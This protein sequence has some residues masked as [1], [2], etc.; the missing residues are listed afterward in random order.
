MHAPI[1]RVT[2]NVVG[3]VP[4]RHDSER[5]PGKNY[6]PFG[7]RPLYH[8]VVA[9]LLASPRIS[10]VVLDTDSE[11]IRD[12]ARAAFPNVEVIERPPHLRDGLVP[13]N[14]V[15]LNDVRKVDADLY[16]QTHSTNPLLREASV[17]RAVDLL[18]GDSG[19]D[20]LFSVTRLQTRL[21]DREGAPINHDRSV[22]A[23]T[24]DLPP[25]FQENSCLYLFTRQGLELHGNR[26]GE[27]PI[28][29]ELP[30]EEAWDIDEDV[31]FRVAEALYA[32]RATA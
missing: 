11:L 12:D 7:G 28:L 24:Q 30:R 6:R 10:K 29:F 3:I 2:A 16:L 15:L 4:M 25:V 22:L 14:E 13:M 8:H 32:S 19:H 20:S 5:V 1:D 18:L 27:R 21:W 23:R 9:T 31:D 17:T 26:I